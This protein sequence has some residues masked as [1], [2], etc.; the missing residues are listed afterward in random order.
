MPHVDSAGNQGPSCF[1][2]IRRARVSATLPP[3]GCGMEWLQTG[4]D[5]QAVDPIFPLQINNYQTPFFGPPSASVGSIK[6]PRFR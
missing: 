4:P 2:I 6:L 5:N 1:I 3:C